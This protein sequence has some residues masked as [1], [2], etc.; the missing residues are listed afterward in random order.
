M[1]DLDLSQF[2]Q[3]SLINGFC[4]TFKPI[5]TL[6]VSE[7]AAKYRILPRS[8]SSSPGP[9]RNEKTP[10]LVEIM[11]TLSPSY[12]CH[13]VVF[14]K[15]SQIGAS[16]AGLNWLMYTIDVAPGPMLA[17]QPTNKAVERWSK[18]RIGPSLKQ[19]AKLQNKLSWGD[20]NTIYQKEFIGGMLILTGANSPAD[21][22]SMPIANIY[23][24][25]TDRYPA[26]AGDEGDPIGLAARR[27]ATFS[28]RKL[29]YTS[30]PTILGYSKIWILFLDSDQR[31]FYVPCP[32]CGEFQTIEFERLTWPKGQPEKVA[33]ACLHCGSLIY[34]HSKTKMLTSGYWK[35][36]NP[37]HHR[38]GFHLSS[39]YSPV[40]WLSWT[41]IARMFETISDDVEMVKVFTNTIL[42]LPYEES[43]EQIAAEYLLR[44]RETYNADIPD[45]VYFLTLAID[46]Q[47]DWIA[48]EICGWGIGEESW[49]IEYGELH[50]DLS[51]MTN[52]DPQ[53][54]SIWERIDQLRR[55]VYQ[56]SD[57]S[58]LRIVCTVIDSGGWWT[59]EVYRYTK[60]LNKYRVY[61]IKGASVFDRPFIS[62]PSRNT[63]NKCRLYVLGVSQGKILVQKRLKK[64]VP[65]SPGYCH[66]PDDE[67][68]GY[69]PEY[70][71][72]LTSEKLTINIKRGRLIREWVKP[73]GVAN[74]PFDLRVYNTAAIKIVD[75]NWS[76]VA[77]RSNFVKRSNMN[78][79]SV[80]T[81]PVETTATDTDIVQT[82]VSEN[83]KPPR[84][85]RLRSNK[86]RGGIL[87]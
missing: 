26:E 22:A 30:T 24:D 7:W 77:R 58:E 65:N 74:E 66:F 81:P 55:S 6:T 76:R 68:R 36:H 45:G 19:C 11:D 43:G 27:T 29:F 57:G 56:R 15:G 8:G 12:P 14:A 73:K 17:V 9:W 72:G 46:V 39:L 35:P 49:G 48:Y 37:G 31:Y 34:E 54:L 61:A 1:N 25:E 20:G 84:K 13:E 21:L 3:R 64:D 60:P 82:I 85:I 44:R 70:Y 10:Y 53:N 33:L 87:I 75:P 16:E 80:E 50:G 41:E 32:H 23:F 2:G 4:A 79:S 71:A 69:D 63:K 83:Q 5:P 62:K 67:E 28:R 78:I 38:V 59:D 51:V 42:G 47:Q 86:K 52:N 40:G 18:Q